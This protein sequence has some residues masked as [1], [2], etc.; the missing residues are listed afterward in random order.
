MLRFAWSKFLGF[1]NHRCG[2]QVIARLTKSLQLPATKEPEG[3]WTL[4]A[5]ARDTY[6]VRLTTWTRDNK[7]FLMSSSEACIERE[8][9]PQELKLM[10][11]EWNGQLE[12][13]AFRL[14]AFDERR[15]VALYRMIDLRSVP[16][17][18]L[19]AAARGVI[20]TMQLFL[21][22]AYAMGLLISGPHDFAD[23]GSN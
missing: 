23:S 1:R 13:S 16:E 2:S 4:L 19:V 8:L 20:E 9:L 6:R 18:E 22:K 21:C 14:L 12:H 3:I 15:V 11:L 7:L 17:N 10:L 5:D